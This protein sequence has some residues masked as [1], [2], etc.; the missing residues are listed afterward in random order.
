MYFYWCDYVKLWQVKE[1]NNWAYG[2]DRIQVSADA[3]EK[4]IIYENMELQAISA[5]VKEIDRSE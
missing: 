1:K 5:I 4:L 2:T 3:R